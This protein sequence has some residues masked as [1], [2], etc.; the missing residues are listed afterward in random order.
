MTAASLFRPLALLLAIAIAA[1]LSAGESDSPNN[2]AAAQQDAI[3]A[4]LDNYVA[5]YNNRD[6]AA[7]AAVWSENGVYVDEQ[8]NETLVGRSAIQRDLETL[9]AADDDSLLSGRIDTIGFIRPDVAHI[10]GRALVVRADEEPREIEFTAVLVRD[11]SQ[12]LLGSV[13]EKVVAAPQSPS[14]KLSDLEFLVG[15][16]VDDIAAARVDTSV[17]WTANRSFLVKSYRIELDGGE[18][19]HGTQVFG[20]DPRRQGIRCWTFDS[21]GAFGEGTCSS[22]DDGWT[23]KLSQTLPDGRLAGATQVI[24]RVDDNTLEFQLIGKEI[25]GVAEPSSDPVRVVRVA[26][27]DGE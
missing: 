26:D 6:A 15:R 8:A 5:A 22:T 24:T 17:R 10:S 25:A 4:V 21:D 20:W 12:W 16:W 27:Q 7:V 18:T 23:V 19:Q 11:A 3:R 13:Q 14:D 2:D 1:A 9:F